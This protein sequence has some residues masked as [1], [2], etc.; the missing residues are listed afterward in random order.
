MDTGWGDKEDP[1]PQLP[2]VLTAPGQGCFGSSTLWS[3]SHQPV[4]HV[5]GEKHDKNAKTYLH[6]FIQA[7]V[8][9]T[10][11]VS[12]YWKKESNTGTSYSLEA[13]RIIFLQDKLG[14]LTNPVNHSH[15]APCVRLL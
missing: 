4:T 8:L 1:F 12:N 9:S 6:K 13:L 10:H 2:L 14:V 11:T 15:S 7:N 3:D 5:P